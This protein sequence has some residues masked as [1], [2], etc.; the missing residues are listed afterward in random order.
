MVAVLDQW[1]QEGREAGR[2]GM[3][4]TVFIPSEVVYI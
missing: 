3:T 2:D 1:W 4:M